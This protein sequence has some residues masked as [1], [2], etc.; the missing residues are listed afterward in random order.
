MYVC[1]AFAQSERGRDIKISHALYID[2]FDRRCIET[3]ADTVNDFVLL[4]FPGRSCGDSENRSYVEARREPT[5]LCSSLTWEDTFDTSSFP[6]KLDL[7]RFLMRW[8]VRAS[9]SNYREEE[10]SRKEDYSSTCNDFSQ[11]S[12]NAI[13]N[14]DRAARESRQ[15]TVRDLNPSF[16]VA[17][18]SATEKREPLVCG[19]TNVMFTWLRVEDDLSI[20]LISTDVDR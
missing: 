4:S 18:R 7:T 16:A 3:L 10:R 11:L 12:L 5:A 17:N 6:T 2:P 20:L 13:V 15:S 19:T 14:L 9:K 8:N 1:I